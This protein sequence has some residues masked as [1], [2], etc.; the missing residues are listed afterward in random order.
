MKNAPVRIVLCADDDPDDRELLCETINKIDPEVKVIHA[1]NGKRLL[2]KLKELDSINVCP[3]LI[4]LDMNMPIM[5]GRQT[6]IEI[7]K[8]PGWGSIPVAIFTTSQRELYRQLECEYGINVVTKP[9]KYAAIITEVTQ[10]L[11]YCKAA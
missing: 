2:S 7:K 4:I 6:L 11:S 10:L 9:A 5:D 8:N 3:C 1:D